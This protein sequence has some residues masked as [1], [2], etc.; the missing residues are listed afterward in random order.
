MGHRE[1]SSHLYNSG[2][3]PLFREGRGGTAINKDSLTV[4]LLVASLPSALEK[5]RPL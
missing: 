2:A 1:K 5:Y 4:A 3:R